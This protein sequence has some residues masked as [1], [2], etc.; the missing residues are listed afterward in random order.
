MASSSKCYL[1]RRGHAWSCHLPPCCTKYGQ[2]RDVVMSDHITTV[3]MS[4]SGHLDQRCTI[5][6]HCSGLHVCKRF[7][8]ARVCLENTRAYLRA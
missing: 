1:Q 7:S 2:R 4:M 5:E 8:N 6:P 3:A